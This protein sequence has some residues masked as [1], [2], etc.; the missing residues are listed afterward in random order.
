MTFD[1]VLR[2]GNQKPR[3]KIIDS[4][5]HSYCESVVLL[6]DAIGYTPD[7]WQEEVL[8]C[9]MA[10]DDYKKYVHMRN[11]LSVP[12][13]NG[14]TALVVVRCSFGALI[15]GERIL[16][17]AHEYST[18]TETLEAFTN[19]FGIKKNDPDAEFPELNAEVSRVRRVNGKEAIF[20][21][22]GG[23][24]HF[25][26]RTKK[27]RRG[28]TYDVVVFDEA[29]ELTESQLK[30]LMSTASSGPKKNPQFI[31]LGTP[32]GPET[33]GDVFPR[34][35]KNVIEGTERKFSWFEWSIEHIGDISDRSRWYETNPGLGTRL[36]EDVVEA[37]LG[38]LEELS[39]AQER[40]GYWLEVTANALISKE[41]WECL[42]I[43]MPPTTGKI[44][45]GVKFSGDDE[46]VSLSV[47]RKPKKGYPHIELIRTEPISKGISWLTKFLI[48]RKDKIAAVVIDGKS[49]VGMLVGKLREAKFARSAIIEGTPKIAATAASLL[50][51]AIIEEMITHFDQE[52]LND[53]ALSAEKRKIGDGWG[54]KGI[55]GA[56]VTPV[57][58]CGLAH[59]GVITTKRNPG[60]KGGWG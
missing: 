51:D 53:S 22:S 14:K 6:A 13:Q 4:F 57:E 45:F 17:T 30:S 58:S 50:Y 27:A 43:S 33:T 32:P 26:T 39:F 59:Y 37:E 36:F 49:G 55:E 40:L 60:R 23:S 2:K 29:Q 10:V 16:Y 31:F 54:W 20:F 1:Q 46:T 12:R 44:A 19:I 11:G 48:P 24:I 18:V 34:I 47:A 3:I 52:Q 25:S 21:K 56:D 41:E 28:Q 9:W 38:T 5:E 15:L 7:E 8:K 35:R 42:A